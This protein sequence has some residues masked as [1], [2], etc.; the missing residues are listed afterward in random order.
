MQGPGPL[1]EACHI[2]LATG[3]TLMFSLM[4][5][6]EIQAARRLYESAVLDPL[7]GLF[8]RRHL[9]AR[10]RAEFAFAVR[11]DSQLSVLIIDVDHFKRIND[12]HGHPAG[13]AALRQLGDRLQRSIRTEDIAARYG[14]EEFAL[15]ARGIESNRALL[16]ADRIRDTVARMRVAHDGV[17]LAF[18]VSIGVATHDGARPFA[19]VDELLKA[20]D[21]ALYQAKANGRNRCVAA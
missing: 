10:L 15:I 16:L 20:A 19:T 6:L 21:S 14:G 8:N 3:I 5:D 1:R 2:Q 9:D 13:D 18:T 17:S 7:T 11:H 12:S 4:D